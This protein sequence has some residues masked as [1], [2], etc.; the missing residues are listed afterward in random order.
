M[1]Q[2]NSVVRLHKNGDRIGFLI[3]Y[4]YKGKLQIGFQKG[5][6][7][8]PQ[9]ICSDTLEVDDFSLGIDTDEGFVFD[10]NFTIHKPSEL[11]DEVEK[12][13]GVTNG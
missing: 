8:I 12:V 7:E 11:L 4:V 1:P 10:E 2:T 6:L 5:L 13:L 3:L 9:P